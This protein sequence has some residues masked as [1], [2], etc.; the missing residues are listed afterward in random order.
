MS[1]MGKSGKQ[2]YDVYL[3]EKFR[4]I[5]AHRIPY[6]QPKH[7]RIFPFTVDGKNRAI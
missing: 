3:D 2:F 5:C 6:P 7:I 4:Q 1:E